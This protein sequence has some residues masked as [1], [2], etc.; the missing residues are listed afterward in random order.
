MTHSQ[1][2][3]F[4]KVPSGLALRPLL[5]LLFFELPMLAL[6]AAA[7]F[8]RAAAETDPLPRLAEGCKEMR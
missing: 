5:S 1:I 8:L 7:I 4:A 2:P 6:C 3:C